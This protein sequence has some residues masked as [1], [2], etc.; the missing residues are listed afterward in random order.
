MSWHWTPSGPRQRR[1]SGALAPVAVFVATN[2]L[3]AARYAL[4]PCSTDDARMHVP[5]RHGF[6][7]SSLRAR[8]SRTKS[9]DRPP[10]GRLGP[11]GACFHFPATPPRTAPPVQAAESHLTPQTDFAS[12]P[13]QQRSFLADV[14]RHDF[15]HRRIVGAVP[16]CDVDRQRHIEPPVAALDLEL[17][18][19]GCSTPSRSKPVS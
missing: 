2:G 12:N 15:L 7:R 11:T 13:A 3:S 10:R 9:P 6:A 1:I 17:P 16:H 19:S 4:R 18:P 8:H 14:Y 5:L